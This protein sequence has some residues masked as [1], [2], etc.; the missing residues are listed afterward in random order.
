[1]VLIFILGTIIGSFLNV[2]IFRL[3][4]GEKLGG[5]S[6]CPNCGKVLGP[7]ELVPLFSLLFQRAKCSGCGNKISW[8]YFSVELI[9]GLLFA[10]TYFLF[11]LSTILD[12]IFLIKALVIISVLI[13]VFVID[14]KYYLILDKVTFWAFGLVGLLN[15]VIDIYSKNPFFSFNSYFISGIFAAVAASLPFFI[16]WFI[17]KGKWMGFG[18]VKFALFLGFAFGLPLVFV[19][20]FLAVIL[21]GVVSIILLL[22]KV[23]SLKS[24]IPFGIFLSLSGVLTL[25][26]GS[27][28]LFWYLAFLGF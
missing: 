17:S 8:Q 9:T 10:V 26:F 16:I 15:I 23:K 12:Y 2:V 7:K 20:I 14:L 6:H 24:Q 13:V 18:D 4:K 5:R 1:M 3:P 27:E 19:S 11:P 28:I 22:F 21:G 25:Y